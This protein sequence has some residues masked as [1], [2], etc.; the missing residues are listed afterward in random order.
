MFFFH[1][2]VLL[3]FSF[4]FYKLKY[5]LVTSLV[6]GIYPFTCKQKPHGGAILSDICDPDNIH[7]LLEYLK[8]NDS[9]SIPKHLIIMKEKKELYLGPNFTAI[10]SRHL[11]RNDLESHELEYSYIIK[12][13]KS[14]NANPDNVDVIEAQFD[15]GVEDIRNLFDE[16]SMSVDEIYHSSPNKQL[17]NSYDLVSNFHIDEND[18]S[19]ESSLYDNLDLTIP[20]ISP[21][22]SD[23]YDL[24][25]SNSDSEIILNS[26]MIERV[27]ITGE[28]TGSF[29]HNNNANVES[30]N[31]PKPFEDLNLSNVLTQPEQNPVS[32]FDDDNITSDKN[33][34]NPCGIDITPPENASNF[35]EHTSTVPDNTANCNSLGN[36][37]ERNAYHSSKAAPREKMKYMNIFLHP[38]QLNDNDIRNLIH[39]NREQF[40]SFVDAIKPHLEK[41]QS[42]KT[43]RKLSKKCK[44]KT[45]NKSNTKSQRTTLSIFSIAF[46]FRLKLAKNKSFNELATLFVISKR[47][48][49]LIYKKVLDIVYKYHVALPDILSGDA[50]EK[51]FDDL[52]N[53]MDPFYRELFRPFKDPIGK[54]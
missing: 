47:T 44:T 4:F 13:K 48:A 54:P 16:E 17:P 43:F 40:F 5:K 33:L 23:Y 6:L 52:A 46:L 9:I 3:F 10:S 22:Q 27:P 12:K 34:T 49:I 32:D 2:W 36:Q 53:S 35:I 18:I 14:S 26:T 24:P 29:S 39:I 41:I 30:C 51:L 25:D 45:K 42:G 11:H 31:I 7:I 8:E 28:T 1:S 50:V 19:I 38:E 15:S 37:N 21:C 20:M